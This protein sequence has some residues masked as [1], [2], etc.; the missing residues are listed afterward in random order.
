VEGNGGGDK[1][2]GD[3]GE[4]CVVATDRDFKR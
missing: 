2:A 1:E 4:E 3:F